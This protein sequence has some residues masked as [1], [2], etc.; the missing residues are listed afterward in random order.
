LPPQNHALQL[1][2]KA[3]SVLQMSKKNLSTYY[4]IAQFVVFMVV[5][6]YG[7]L[8]TNTRSDARQA[9]DRPMAL[10]IQDIAPDNFSEFKNSVLRPQVQRICM[11]QVAE[12]IADEPESFVK[13]YCDCYV[14]RVT[15]AV[16]KDDMIYL[17]HNREPS[18]EMESRMETIRQ[19]ARQQCRS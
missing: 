3:G 10:S 2:L 17:E 4:F 18:S 12:I 9:A 14:E 11:K 15:E 13:N 7:G 16:T 6:P 5:I 1:F 19:S 8:V